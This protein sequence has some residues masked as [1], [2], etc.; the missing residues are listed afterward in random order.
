MKK[1]L[2][3][4][5]LIVVIFSLFLSFPYR[6]SAV[7][8]I[9][10][11]GSGGGSQSKSKSY[12]LDQFAPGY[13]ATDANTTVQGAVSIVFVVAAALTFAYLIYGAITWITSG[14]EKSKVES[15]RNKITS[16][17]IGLIILASV[18]AIYNLVLTVA[19]GGND[20]SLPNLNDPAITVPEPGAGVQV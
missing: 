18:W 1:I 4:L 20:I 17:A 2:S 15:A 8:V 19:F 9:G 11:D 12:S 6:A 3:R 16:A 5:F 14:G 10:T 13:V 7:N